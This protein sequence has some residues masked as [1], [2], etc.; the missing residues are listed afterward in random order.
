MSKIASQAE[1]CP[2]LHILNSL[3]QYICRFARGNTTYNGFGWRS[4]SFKPGWRAR[5]HCDR[6]RHF[7]VSILLSSRLLCCIEFA[8]AVQIVLVVLASEAWKWT[9]P[10]IAMSDAREKEYQLFSYTMLSDLASLTVNLTAGSMH[11]SMSESSG[12][13]WTFLGQGSRLF[14]LA[15]P[16]ICSKLWNIYSRSWMEDLRIHLLR[17][18]R[19]ANLRMEIMPRRITVSILTPQLLSKITHLW[20]LHLVSEHS[21]SSSF[22]QMPPSMPSP[23]SQQQSHN[24]NCRAHKVAG[25]WD[26]YG[27]KFAQPI[28]A[29]QG[30]MNSHFTTTINKFFVCLSLHWKHALMNLQWNGLLSYCQAVRGTRLLLK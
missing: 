29:R 11:R 25:S 21:L 9:K 30:Y 12:K 22:K 18:C 2:W 23:L 28:C 1:H 7:Q 20:Y 13:I 17:P 6:W 15:S 27:Y 26:L 10:R 19:M 24:S 14:W 8:S 5:G 3:M 16:S 4:G